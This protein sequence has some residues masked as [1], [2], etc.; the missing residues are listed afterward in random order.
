MTD[1]RHHAICRGTDPDVFFPNQGASAAP[2]R[3]ICND[4]PV[5]D[6]CGRWALTQ[7]IPD[8]VWGGMSENQRRQLL[9][10]RHTPTTAPTES[11]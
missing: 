1:W 4:C 3:R 5:I 11:Q 2:A 8:G 6:P 7:R 9:N 10:A